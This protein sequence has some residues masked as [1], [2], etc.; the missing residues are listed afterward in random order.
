MPASNH[1]RAQ[2]VTQKKVCFICSYVR[3]YI[4]ILYHGFCVLTT[5]PPC[6]ANTLGIELSKLP[7]QFCLF[8]FLLR[9]YLINSPRLHW[10]FAPSSLSKPMGSWD[11]RS[12]LQSWLRMCFWC[13]DVFCNGHIDVDL[14][15]V[16]NN[17]S[18]QNT[19][20]KEMQC[21]KEMLCVEHRAV[22]FVSRIVKG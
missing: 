12:V 19:S 11:Y 7:T 22:L 14:N 15:F 4:C 21:R 16:F 10:H 20:G 2:K 1:L 6:E 8:L 5:I 9:Q 18:V 17:V 13:P 3:T